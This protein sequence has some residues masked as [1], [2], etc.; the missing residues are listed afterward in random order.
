MFNLI[1][2]CTDE[3]YLTNWL[4][5]QKYDLTSLYV[6]VYWNFLFQVYIVAVE[7]EHEKETKPQKEEEEYGESSRESLLSLVQPELPT[8]SQ[9]WLGALRDYAYLSLPTGTSKICEW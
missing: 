3:N 6:K 4:S 9:N 8:L 2:G 5:D 1:C 7:R